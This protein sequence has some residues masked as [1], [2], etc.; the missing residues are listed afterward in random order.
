MKEIERILKLLEEGKI[1]AEEAARLIEAIKEKEEKRKRR[2]E[3]GKEGIAFGFFDVGKVIS[4]TLRTA[5]S[6]VP[7][8][9]S[10]AYR[11]KSLDKTVELED[12]EHIRLNLSAGDLTINT[13][14]GDALKLE[15]LG[16]Y[17]YENGGFTLWGDLEIQVPKTKELSLTVQGGDADGTLEADRINIEV[18]AGDG[19]F[20]LK[21][22]EMEVVV[23][24]GDLDIELL[25]APEFGKVQCSMG[26]LELVLPENYEGTIETEVKMGN[27]EIKRE[28]YKMEKG[29][30]IFG[31]GEGS[32]I[33]VLCKMGNVEIS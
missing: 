27:L 29:R 24:M 18:K 16:G 26:D 10:T 7:L 30:I 28:G 20:E 23:K 13:Y 12:K 33:V 25:N 14:E 5:F 22:R 6:S 15:G 2:E 4:D 1:N 9:F 19:E 32:R 11:K 3:E 17:G 31:K 21:A 8:V